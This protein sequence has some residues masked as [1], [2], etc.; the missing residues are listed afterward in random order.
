MQVEHVSKQRRQAQTVSVQER[1][2]VAIPRV[3]FSG[4]KRPQAI[5]TF[6]VHVTLQSLAARDVSNKNVGAGVENG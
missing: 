6:L 5:E 4:M 1:F 3:D 2:L